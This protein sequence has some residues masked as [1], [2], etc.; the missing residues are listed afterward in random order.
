ML[1]DPSNRELVDPSNRELVKPEQ[2]P[3]SRRP[4][5]QR[6]TATDVA[7]HNRR[8]D[9]WIIVR[10]KVYDITNFINHHPG[11]TN[12]GQTSTVLAIMKNLG[13]EC[14]EEFEAIHT[15]EA[16]ALLPGYLVGSVARYYGPSEVLRHIAS[17]LEWRD[18][19]SAVVAWRDF[20]N[21]CLAQGVLVRGAEAIQTKDVVQNGELYSKDA[22]QGQGMVQFD[23]ILAPWAVFVI[24]I[25]RLRA[26]KLYVGGFYG[27]SYSLW[28]DCAGTARTGLPAPI[29]YG[30]RVPEGSTLAFTVDTRH[31]IARYYVD[32]RCLGS[33][34]LPPSTTS[35]TTYRPYLLLQNAPGDAI[36]LVRDHHFRLCPPSTT[37]AAPEFEQ[38]PPPHRSTNSSNEQKDHPLDGRLVVKMLGPDATEFVALKLNPRSAT[39]AKLKRHLRTVLRSRKRY[40]PDCDLQIIANGQC[41]DESDLLADAGVSIH[42]DTRVQS[43]DLYYCLP[44][45]VS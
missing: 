7:R 39:V 16:K 20:C 23:S 38:R 24:K 34:P 11:W 25:E 29:S 41:L 19:A 9:A 45:T 44:H 42:P 33:L 12:G 1:V 6:Y 36:S 21:A 26:L 30:H 8:D 22:T 35:K 40:P 37:T 4:Q 31:R 10:D 32:G 14:T 13:Q 28:F 15:P 2:L 5:H 43:I 27:K 17:W 18:V 3:S